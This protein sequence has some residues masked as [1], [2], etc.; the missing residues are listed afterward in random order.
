MLVFVD[1]AKQNVSMTFLTFQL[2]SCMLDVVFVSKNFVD[3]VLYRSPCADGN[4]VYDNMGGE[5]A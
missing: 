1:L 5:G 3:G 4:I 2:E